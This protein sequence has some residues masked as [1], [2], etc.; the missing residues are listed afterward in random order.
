[1]MVSFV[2]ILYA[3]PPYALFLDDLTVAVVCSTAKAEDT[4][5]NVAIEKAVIIL[6]RFLLIKINT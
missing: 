6:F 4:H 2:G 1:M 5:D 3:I